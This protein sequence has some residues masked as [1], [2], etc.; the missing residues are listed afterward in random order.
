MP[1]ADLDPLSRRLPIFPLDLANLTLIK[2]PRPPRFN[3]SLR[4]SFTCQNTFSPVKTGCVKRWELY[5]PRPSDLLA[6]PIQGRTGRGKIW[7]LDQLNR[8]QQRLKEHSKGSTVVPETECYQ[9]STV[10]PCEKSSGEVKK[11]TM[12]RY[13]RP[14]ITAWRMM[15]GSCRALVLYNGISSILKH[16]NFNRIRNTPGSTNSHIE[17]MDLMGR[18]REVLRDSCP[19]SSLHV[20]YS[21]CS[22]LA[23]LDL[24]IS[25]RPLSPYFV[26]IVTTHT[27]N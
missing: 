5:Y 19:Q 15:L 17:G 20:S 9:H 10:C 21:N 12:M 2:G 8:W 6:I 16:Q 22:Y 14:E 25:F 7:L 1:A 23:V 13:M 4:A 3:A 24:S 18:A 27:N 26:D 11:S